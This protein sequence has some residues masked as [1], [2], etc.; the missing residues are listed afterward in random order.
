MIVADASLVLAWL[1][2]E[3]EHAPVGDAFDSLATQPL[4]VPANWSAEI[5]NGLRRACRNGRLHRDDIFPLVDRLAVLD[6]R[7]ASPARTSDIAALAMLAMETSL[8]A[9]DAGYVRLALDR[10]ISLATVDRPM[11]AAA[12]RLN[13]PLIPA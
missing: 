6:V 10:Q 3:P 5:A 4:V 12:R 9:Y 2:E 7:V 13:V 1:L 8:S 11:R